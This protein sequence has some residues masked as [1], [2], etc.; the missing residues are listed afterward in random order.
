MTVVVGVLNKKGVAI[1][2]DSAVTNQVRTISPIGEITD[3][4]EKI[5][6][7]GN[8]MLRISDVIPVSAMVVN[9]ANLLGVPWDVIIRWYRKQRGKVEF[10]SVEELVKD[11]LDFIPKQEFFI[12]NAFKMN[13][14]YTTELVFSGYGTDQGYPQLIYLKIN[15][16]ANSQ[17]I[18]SKNDLQI[19]T[20]SEENPSAIQYFGQ[21]EIA[22]TLTENALENEEVN[23]LYLR[24]SEIF[25]STTKLLTK[26][27]L[28]KTGTPNF[29]FGKRFLSIMENYHKD[30]R[31]RWIEVVKDYSLQQMAALAENL[32]NA[33]ELYQQIT[34]EKEYVGGLIDLAV[35]TKV[36]GFQWLNRKS[37]YTPS[38]G[39]QYGK[40]GI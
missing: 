25:T 9:N 21:I 3:E 16:V 36:D 19:H 18:F 12:A 1:A 39:G 32:I 15:G 35:I 26:K 40:F 14:P 13:W 5:V 8:K 4:K 28:I 38:I 27:G 23:A 11:F 20:I 30:E 24:M 34:F 22:A 10:S 29:N 33:T 17:L 31:K 6:N 7:S 2:A 37:W